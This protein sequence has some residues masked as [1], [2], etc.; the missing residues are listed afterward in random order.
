MRT[1]TPA[2]LLLF[3]TMIFISGCGRKTATV[4]GK[5]I[6]QTKP[7]HLGQISFVN[8]K[9]DSASGTINSDGTYVVHNAPRGSVIAV[10]V[11]VESDGGQT[12]LDGPAPAKLPKSKSLVP[13]KYNTPET[14][15]LKFDISS[16]S[17]TIDI[18]L[19]D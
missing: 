18:E 7:I 13:V 16:N 8:G 1:W 19:K 11:S 3:I 9:G 5:I 4:K 14:S 10:I 6:Y 12:R 2:T 15:D 17:Q